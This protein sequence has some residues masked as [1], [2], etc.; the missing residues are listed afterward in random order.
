VDPQTHTHFL[1]NLIGGL[2]AV[3]ALF[4][5]TELLWRLMLRYR[6]RDTVRRGLEARQMKAAAERW[7]ATH[8]RDGTDRRRRTW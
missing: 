5:A 6:W 7:H 1:R 4:L 8:R 3:P 2:A